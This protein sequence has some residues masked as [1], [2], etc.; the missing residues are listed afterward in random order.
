MISDTSFTSKNEAINNVEFHTYLKVLYEFITLKYS[1][2][3]HLFI[4]TYIHI[5]NRL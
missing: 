4:Y 5:I 1:V 3:N 2:N